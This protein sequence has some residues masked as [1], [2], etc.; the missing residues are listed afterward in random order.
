MARFYYYEEDGT[1]MTA[2]HDSHRAVEAA[3]LEKIG[4]F[5]A[6][7]PQMAQVDA[8]ASQRGYSSRDCIKL[9]EETPDLETKLAIF[10]EEHLHDDEEIRYI[11]SGEGYFDVRDLNDEWIR[12]HVS[13]GDMLILPLGIFHRFT[14]TDALTI[15][16]TRLFKDEPKWVAIPRTTDSNPTSTSREEYLNTISSF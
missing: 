4:V 11:T 10:F 5:Y 15:G 2:P 8:L 13:A 14:L 12:C 7:L 9:S 16:A 3:Q 6:N 1:S